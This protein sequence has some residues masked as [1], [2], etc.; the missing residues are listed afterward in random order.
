M[1]KPLVAQIRLIAFMADVS[2][3]VGPRD[4]ICGSDEPWVGDRPERFANIRG[5]CYI[6]VCGKKNRPQTRSI[7]CVAEASICRFLCS[8]EYQDLCCNDVEIR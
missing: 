3:K 4:T 1:K 5:V 7:G 6:S 8:K 2:D